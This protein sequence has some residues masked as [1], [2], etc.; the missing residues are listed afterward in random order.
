MIKILLMFSLVFA[1]TTST[2]TAQSVLEYMTLTYA[3]VEYMKSNFT[4]KSTSTLLGGTEKSSGDLEYAKGKFRL[5][6][7]G[8]TRNI[9]IKGDESF[10]HI[11]DKTVL[12]GDVSK[13]VP[14]VG[15]PN[16]TRE[17]LIICSMLELSLG[18]IFLIIMC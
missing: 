18:S 13:A 3:H 11:N 14:T 1:K 9:F 4:K 7:K 8:K 16:S 17:A 10:W 12:V 6:L 2:E 15:R 5:E